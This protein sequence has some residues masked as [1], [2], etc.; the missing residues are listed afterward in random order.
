MI[1][2]AIEIRVDDLRGAAIA[3]FL[4]EHLRSLAD[5]TVAIPQA[6]CE[7]RLRAGETIWTESSHKFTVAELR[8]MA[9]ANGFVVRGQWVD[10]E[11][12][13]AESLWIAS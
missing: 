6:D 1:E 4:S 9:V 8:Q 12:P 7:I 3:E 10:E 2:T 5:Q 13:F 11:W